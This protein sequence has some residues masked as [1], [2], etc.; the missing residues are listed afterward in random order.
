MEDKK[1]MSV[2]SNDP[3]MTYIDF[4][5]MFERV[6]MST[7]QFSKHEIESYITEWADRITDYKNN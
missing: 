1:V 6:V 2:S 5:K 4:M 7:R 3:D